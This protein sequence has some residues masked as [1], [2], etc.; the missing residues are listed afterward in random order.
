[1]AFTCLSI[2]LLAWIGDSTGLPFI[3]F[4]LVA[5]GLGFALFSSPNANAIMSSV[6]P[7]YLGVASG[8]MGTMR[9][10]GQ[11]LSMGLA[12][13]TFSVVIGGVKIVPAVYPLFLRS[14]KVALTVSATLCLIGIFFSLARGRVRG[15]A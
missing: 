13:M 9:L 11:M 3:V 2:Y 10:L 5:L 12:M 1:M 8:T 6:E 14:V 7:R 15:E 4:S